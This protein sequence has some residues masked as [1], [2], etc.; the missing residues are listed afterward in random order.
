MRS[1]PGWPL[2]SS[3]PIRHKQERGRPAPAGRTLP[4]S[5]FGRLEQPE[6]DDRGDYTKDGSE[7]QS[8]HEAERQEADER[9]EEVTLR[10]PARLGDL[11]A[12]SK[13]L[14]DQIQRLDATIH[15]PPPTASASGNPFEFQLRMLRAA[16]ERRPG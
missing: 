1:K 14:T 12:R 15:A 6:Y 16:F 2:P 3:R 9:A 13:K 11:V 10:L 4:P 5:V 8:H 7:V